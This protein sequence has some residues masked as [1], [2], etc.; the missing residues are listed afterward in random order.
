MAVILT[1]I[2]NGM[3]PVQGVTEQGPRKGE[4]WEFLSLEISDMVPG[5]V[6][7]CQI[8]SDDKD[9]ATLAQA[10]LKGHK[11]KCTIMSQT[12][13]ER[14]LKDSRTVMQIRTTITNVRDLG[15]PQ[16]ED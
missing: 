1:G 15:I 6:W 16:D 12:A 3:R 5:H 9:Y 13:S 8:R 14:T 10:E 4:T 11:V 7:S 2:V